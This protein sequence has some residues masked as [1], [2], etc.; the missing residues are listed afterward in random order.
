MT[1]KNGKRVPL[2]LP[3]RDNLVFSPAISWFS[4]RLLEC[5]AI[6]PRYTPMP[7]P[8]FPPA[9]VGITAKAEAALERRGHLPIA[10]TMLNRH[11]LGDCGDLDA[12]DR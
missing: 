6:N 8:L 2:F 5:F 7:K 10:Q 9:Q 4:L 12:Q 3:S 11:A 1:S